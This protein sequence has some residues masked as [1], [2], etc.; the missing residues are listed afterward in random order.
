MFDAVSDPD[1]PS[2]PEPLPE[3]QT[4]PEKKEGRKFIGVRFNCCGIYKRI[5][6]NEEGTAYEGRCPKCFR[7]VKFTVGSGGTDHRFFDVN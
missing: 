6:I 1:P 4:P 2:P 3:E 5:Y 7:Q